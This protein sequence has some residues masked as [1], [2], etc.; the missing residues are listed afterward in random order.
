MEKGTSTAAAHA[1]ASSS[2]SKCRIP[3][4]A[5]GDDSCPRTAVPHELRKS[6]FGTKLGNGIWELKPLG[7]STAKMAA[8][9]GDV[10]EHHLHDDWRSPLLSG[11]TL[12]GRRGGGGELDRCAV[13][14]P[15]G[16]WDRAGARAGPARARGHHRQRG[17][18]LPCHARGA[19]G[20]GMPAPCSALRAHG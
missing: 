8:A 3:Q 7:L 13:L 6:I 20:A 15:E 2:A 14:C 16:L 5:E 18:G 19:G 10:W 4:A 12:G 11:D 9:A 17:T 1:A